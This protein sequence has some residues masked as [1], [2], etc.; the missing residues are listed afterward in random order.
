MIYAF[1]HI[2]IFHKFAYFKLD[3]FPVGSRVSKL[4]DYSRFKFVGIFGEK[5]L[6]VYISGLQTTKE[7]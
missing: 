4:P 1:F 7:E 5:R 2:V 3:E 6:K